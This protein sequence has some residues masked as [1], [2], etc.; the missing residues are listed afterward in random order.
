MASFVVKTDLI[1]K[2]DRCSPSSPMECPI[3]MEALTSNISTTECGHMYHTQC[4]HTWTRTNPTCP[5][6]RCSF[7]ESPRVPDLPPIQHLRRISQAIREVNERRPL[8]DFTGEIDEFDIA[9]VMQQAD[10]DR[11]TA[12]ASICSHSGDL[13]NAI[14]Y[15]VY[16]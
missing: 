13:T 11:A 8:E 3:C 7:E 9:L 6:C 14:L 2:Y 4:L 1:K 16:R 15:L 10:V 12:Y 5:L